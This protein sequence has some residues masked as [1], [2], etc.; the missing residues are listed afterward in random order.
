[1]MKKLK[2]AAAAAVMLFA[3]SL[4]NAATFSLAGNIDGTQSGTGSPATGLATATYDNI[5]G[6]F[7]WNV[8]WTPLLGNITVMHF[9]GPASPGNNAGVQ[10]DIGAISGLASPSAGST[11]ISAAQGNDLLAGLWYV[12]IHSTL[13][14]GGEIRGQMQ[15]IPLPAAA[16]LLLSG[17]GALGFL[18]R[19]KA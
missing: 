7:S 1:M 4:A 6:L 13:F 5:S 9:H 3:G 19:K 14:P 18:G 15:V 11:T 10:V 12:N 16:W 17:L 8:S 2:I